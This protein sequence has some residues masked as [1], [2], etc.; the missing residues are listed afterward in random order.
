[1]ANRRTLID[2]R[3]DFSE[4]HRPM[5]YLQLIAG[6]ALLLGGA[7]FLVRGAVTLAQRLGVTPLVIGMT[8]VA[9]GTSAPELVVCVDAALSGAPG[10]ALGNVVG[11]NIAN[12]LLILGTSAL[13]MP[14]A[15]DAGMARDN[16]VLMGGS[17][18]FA[19]LCWTGTLGLWPGVALLVAFLAFLGYSYRREAVGGPGAA[20]IDI[21]EASQIGGHPMVPWLALVLLIGGLA[22]VIYGADLLVDGGVAVARSLG[23]SEEVIGLTLIAVGT[24]L[25]E[26]AASVVAAVRGHADMVL[27]N[28]IG[29]N[30]FNILGVAGTAAVVAP[31]AVPD[32]IRE[33]DLGVMLA[34]TALLIAFL[35]AGRRVGRAVGVLFLIAYT[36]YIAIQS[37]GFSSLVATI[38]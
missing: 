12:I 26:L 31:L 18:L 5:M 38:G 13:L 32:Q 25:P 10:I 29:S 15:T 16:A 9:F 34:A 36:A 23:V 19:G 6:F 37:Y 4:A 7:E 30:L 11:S 20:G 21:D 27:G 24:S 2:D 8:V 14:V 33:F 28:V 22:G 3:P 35:M 17:V 1:M